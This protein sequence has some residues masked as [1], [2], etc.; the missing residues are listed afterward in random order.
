MLFLLLLALG[1]A[2]Q[3]QFRRTGEL[4]ISANGRYFTTASG[5]PFFWLGDTGWLLFN[6]LNREDAEKYLEDRRKKGFNV[7]QAMLVHNVRQVNA[8]GDSALH[9]HNVAQPA[10]TEGNNFASPAQYDYW[11]HV[12]YI[13]DK[14]AEKGIYM[15]LVPVWGS[16]VKAGQVSRQQAKTYAAWLAA[17]YRDRPNIIWLN[18]GDIKGSDSTATWK[19]IGHTLHAQDPHHLITF[20]PRG[21]TPSS[22]WFHNEPW[23]HFNMFQSGHRT[24]SQD[25]SA[26]EQLHY[27]ED[28]WKYIAA[29][30]RKTPVKPTLD[31]EPSYEGIPQGL[32][33]T[34]QPY[35]TDSDVRRYGYWSVFAGGAGYTYGHNAVMQMHHPGDADGSYG[36]KDYWYNAINHPGAGQMVHLKNL[37]LSRPYFERV[38]DQS[39]IAGEPGERYNRLLATRGKQYAFIYTYNGRTMQIRMGR[40][41]GDSVKASWYNPRNGQ[42]TPAGK[43]RNKGVAT[44]DPPGE[45]QDGNDWVLVLDTYVPGREVYLFTSFR[46]P[47]TDGLHF[48]YS[49]DGYHWLDMGRSFL[50]PEIGPNRLMRDPSMVQGPDGTFHLVWTSGWKG[51]KGFG[52]ASSKDLLHWSEQQ[53]IPVMEQEPA[54]VNVWA[55]ELYYDKAAAQFVIIWASTIPHRFPRGVEA[56]DNNHRMYYVTTKDFK[57]FSPARLFLDPG[58][59]VIDAVIV[60][61]EPGKYV[62]VLKDNTRPERNIKVAFGKQALGPYTGV[63]APF[64]G[65][66]TEGP[67]VTKAGK[68]WLIY[69]DA[70]RSKA[71]GA[72]KTTDFKTFTDISADVRVPEGHKHGTI[73][74]VKETVLDQLLK[75]Q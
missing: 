48:L 51:D 74:K 63:S 26:A 37:L 70:Y 66:F 20:H 4:K 55:P 30:Y 42:V 46:E 8:Y 56:E 10:I 69:F 47:A 27:G 50:R 60:Q 53:F 28:N 31:G 7:I 71:Y 39:L 15:A 36:V 34:T 67:T 72:V 18:G 23:L 13:V 45:Q 38:P 54:T 33:D 6:K 24:Y 25:T 16:N 32:H 68:D 29:D 44:F 64:T 3:T 17:R 73:I 52:Y 22:Q 57:T 9:N 21:R 75:S 61:Q 14:A 58:F 59:S 5:A 19:I 11:D 40:I 49:Y 1:A 12:D 35:W 65:H 43:F 2:A 62:L 41:A